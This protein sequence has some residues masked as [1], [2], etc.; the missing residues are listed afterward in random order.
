MINLNLNLILDMKAYN[1]IL[2]IKMINIAILVAY[3]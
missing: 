1:S 3:L 2:H